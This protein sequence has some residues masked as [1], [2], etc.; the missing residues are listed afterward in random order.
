MVKSNVFI[1]KRNHCRKRQ[2]Y[3]KKKKVHGCKSTHVNIFFLENIDLKMVLIFFT[4][5]DVKGFFRN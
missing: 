3:K 5:N 4:K 2:I 1:L